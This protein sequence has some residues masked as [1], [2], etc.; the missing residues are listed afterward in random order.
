MAAGRLVVGL[1]R[2]GRLGDQE[3]G[4]PR[5]VDERVGRSRVAAVDETGR[6]AVPGHRDGPGRHVVLHE[7]RPEVQV[8]DAERLAIAIFVELEGIVEE[9]LPLGDELGEGAESVR[10]ALRQPDG[11]PIDPGP[12]PRIEIAEGGEVDVMIGVEVADHDAAQGAGVGRG[13]AAGRRLPTRSRAGPPS[14]PIRR[15]GPMPVYPSAVRPD[16]NRPPSGAWR[17]RTPG[18][19][20]RTWRR[21][22]PVDGR[23]RQRHDDHGPVGPPTAGSLEG[24]R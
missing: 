9:A 7:A 10:A 8:P 12:R 19:H 16:P 21:W 23:R 13:S 4:P 6:A 14:K 20:A 3:V 15:A 24:L 2:Q 17:S 22:S 1:A 18:M 5:R 11:R